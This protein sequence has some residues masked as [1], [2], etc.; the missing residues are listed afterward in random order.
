ME[1]LLGKWNGPTRFEIACCDADHEGEWD[2][3]EYCDAAQADKVF[4]APL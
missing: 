1:Y 3:A 4:R 2:G